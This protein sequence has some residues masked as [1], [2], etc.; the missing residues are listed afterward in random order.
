MLSEGQFGTYHGTDAHIADGGTINPSRDRNYGGEDKAY[1]STDKEVAGSFAHAKTTGGWY[2]SK[3]PSEGVQGKL[4]APVY[5]VSATDSREA[6][7]SMASSEKTVTSTSGFKVDGVAGWRRTDN[8]N[9]REVL[10]GSTP[11]G[12]WWL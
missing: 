7:Q 2:D 10:G 4:F 8:M 1:A 5:K 9:P 11:E 3:L 12:G 6:P